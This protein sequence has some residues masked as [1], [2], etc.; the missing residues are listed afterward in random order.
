MNFK[1]A[2]MALITLFLITNCQ[3][4]EH[5]SGDSATDGM[6]KASNKVAIYHLTGNG[7]YHLI[8]VNE[9]AV[10]AHLA[11]GDL[12]ADVTVSYLDL[13]QDAGDVL[14]DPTRWYF[15]NDDPAN[16]GIDPDLGTF[17]SGP[18][19]PV[20]GTGSAQI[21][22]SGDQKYNLANSQFG[23]TLLSDI[24]SFAFITYNPSAGNGGPATRSG[25]VHFNVSFDG[26]V[27]YQFRLIF[28]PRDNGT[29]MQD[30][31]QEWDALGD[32]TTLWRWSGFAAYGNQWPDGNTD[33]LRTWNDLLSAFPD[34]EMHSLY[35]FVGIRVGEPY[36]DGYTENIDAFKFGVNGI[37]QVF[38]FED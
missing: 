13:A 20:E 35:P 33:A 21:S 15:Y 28:V 16:E 19:T 11:H 31:W 3:K 2:A 8:E 27:T 4:N 37:D 7:S 36:P 38:D 32:G 23:G 25:Y 1:L 24:S 6:L 22:V 17:V 29:V 14:E 18:G 10:P 30:T 26:T 34:I 5:I 9:N 12:L